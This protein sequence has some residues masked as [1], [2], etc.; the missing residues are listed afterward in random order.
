MEPRR[1]SLY[2]LFGRAR[3]AAEADPA[4]FD[5]AGSPWH[6]RAVFV[7]GA[8]R[9][10]TTWLHQLLATH[11]AVATGGESH[12][13]CEGMGDLLANH[14]DPDPYMKLSTW[15]SRGR[16]LQLMRGLADEVFMAVRDATRP[17]ATV[18]VDKTP[19]HAPHADA[20][21][22]VYPDAAFVHIVR[23]ARDAV[24]SAKDL[25]SHDDTYAH[26]DV[27]AA[28]WVDAVTDVRTNLVGRRYLEVRYEDLVADTPAVLARILDHC[29]LPHDPGFLAA[30][31]DFAATPINVRP[32]ATTVGA[33]KWADADPALQRRIVRVA[34]DVLI[35]SGHL[36]RAERDRIL[37][38]ATVR[39]RA[40]EAGRW[41][42]GR[43]RDA[44]RAARARMV[45]ARGNRT[46]K[47]A[48][49][50]LAD[51]AVAGDLATVVGLLA[52]AV[53]AVRDGRTVRGIDDVA[54]LLLEVLAEGTV[55][56]V[57]A[58]PEAAAVRAR[59]G[60]GAN[61]LVTVRVDGAGRVS[62]V[63]VTG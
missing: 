23:D 18:V 51:A 49:T 16:L 27:A 31:T 40:G 9:S 4:T 7:V 19:N 37:G 24:L 20:L 30:A 29:E 36:D 60:D 28:R 59:G 2:E 55:T 15:V 57:D 48:A 39:E 63:E 47:A 42:A 3:A 45:A 46:V 8:P 10:G 1:E 14:A 6:R 34:G 21:A 62:G 54:G 13:F 58:D 52:D 61:V 5:P 41:L 22:A 12:L 33:R 25:W 44:A 17:E 50:A 26:V 56:A 35:G 32:S 53:T 38:E 43:G 11:P